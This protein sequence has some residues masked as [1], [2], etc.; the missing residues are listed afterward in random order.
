[1]AV[2]DLSPV[3]QLVESIKKSERFKGVPVSF[4]AKSLTLGGAPPRVVLV[5]TVEEYEAPEHDGN[6]LDA[7]LVLEGHVWGKTFDQ[8]RE[9]RS[10]LLLAVFDFQLANDLLRLRADGGQ[11]NTEEDGE[12]HGT[13]VIVSFTVRDTIE[14]VP[15]AANAHSGEIDEVDPQPAP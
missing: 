14:K 10:R 4:G 7:P 11:W 5:P 2:A 6:L 3:M 13:G 12:Q 9:L 15:L 8:A 1:M